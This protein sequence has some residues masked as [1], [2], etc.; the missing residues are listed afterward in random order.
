MLITFKISLESTNCR[1]GCSSCRKGCKMKSPLSEGQRETVLLN[2]D[3][4][5]NVLETF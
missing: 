2:G 3:L 1:S 4:L 5:N